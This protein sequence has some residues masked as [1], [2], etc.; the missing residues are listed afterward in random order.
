MDDTAY[1]ESLA[2]IQTA[3]AEDKPE[4]LSAEDW[5]LWKGMPV[6]AG[7]LALQEEPITF[8]ALEDYEG[9]EDYLESRIVYTGRA[10]QIGRRL[11]RESKAGYGGRIE[12]WQ[13]TTLISSEDVDVDE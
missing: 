11:L 6:L 12:T 2:R 13:G 10:Q 4:S 1:R 3:I 9:G 7:A 8:I 5:C